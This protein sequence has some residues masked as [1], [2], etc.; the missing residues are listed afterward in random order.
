MLSFNWFCSVKS[1]WTMV[2]NFRFI[3]GFRHRKIF[4]IFQTSEKRRSDPRDGVFGV[5]MTFATFSSVT[6]DTFAMAKVCQMKVN[7]LEPWHARHQSRVLPSGAYHVVCIFARSQKPLDVIS[8]WSRSPDKICEKA[9]NLN[10][11]KPVAL[12][13]LLAGQRGQPNQGRP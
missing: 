9:P 6:V 13:G 5:W 1:N 3:A 12:L 7:V 11:N 2:L 8:A 4:E 10:V